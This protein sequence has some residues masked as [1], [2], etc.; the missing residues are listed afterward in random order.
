MFIYL[1]CRKFNFQALTINRLCNT[2]FLKLA[3]LTTSVLRQRVPAGA[4]GSKAAARSHTLI[5]LQ[6]IVVFIKHVMSANNLR[7]KIQVNSICIAFEISY[8]N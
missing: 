4:R 8:I 5:F 6:N 7:P 2:K 3:Y 1:N